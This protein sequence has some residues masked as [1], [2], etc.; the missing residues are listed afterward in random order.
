VLSPKRKRSTASSSNTAPSKQR[1]TSVII[2][3]AIEEAEAKL[4]DERAVL[5]GL[6]AKEKKLMEQEKTSAEKAASEHRVNFQ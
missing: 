6:K 1:T 2:D 3:K 5:K 4:R